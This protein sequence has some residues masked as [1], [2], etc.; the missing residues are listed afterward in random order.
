MSKVSK[1]HHGTRLS[2]ITD[3]TP[4]SDEEQYSVASQDEQVA[5]ESVKIVYETLII[6]AP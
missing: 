4:Q 6:E 2:E 1:A 5:L 3:T